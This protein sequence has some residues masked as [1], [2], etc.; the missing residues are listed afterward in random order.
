MTTDYFH[1]EATAFRDLL[2]RRDMWVG[3]SPKIYSAWLGL[4]NTV[5]LTSDWSERE[6]VVLESLHLELSLRTR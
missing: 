5:A 1:A 2:G 6:Q 4:L 3:P